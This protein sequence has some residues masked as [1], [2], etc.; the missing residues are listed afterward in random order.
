MPK[1][2]AEKNDS[3]DRGRPLTVVGLIAKYQQPGEPLAEMEVKSLMKVI[4]S[5]S[6]DE[7]FEMVS[8]QNAPNEAAAA[9]VPILA[10]LIA[11]VLSKAAQSPRDFLALMDYLYRTTT[12]R[13]ELYPPVY[14]IN[15][16]QQTTETP[17]DTTEDTVFY[18]EK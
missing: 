18:E 7:I 10:E 16:I 3:K 1:H 5:M 6:K 14:N 15:W 8:P 11:S 17:A 4:L 2:K 12:E 13:A 9:K